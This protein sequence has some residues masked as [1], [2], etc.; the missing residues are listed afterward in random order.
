MLFFFNYGNLP[1]TSTS[2]ILPFDA[3]LSF[4]ADKVTSQSLFR[5]PA[6]RTALNGNFPGNC[7]TAIASFH[8]KSTKQKER[9]TKI[10]EQ[11]PIKTQTKSPIGICHPK[12]RAD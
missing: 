2:H 9:Q 6:L 7:N 5:L 3:T 10:V 8:F 4:D 11:F 1:L 12:R